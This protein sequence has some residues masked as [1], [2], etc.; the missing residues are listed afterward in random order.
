MF[1]KGSISLPRVF[2][3]NSGSVSPV[4]RPKYENKETSRA[5]GRAAHLAVP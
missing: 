4:Y 5:T 3:K 2:P 1:R